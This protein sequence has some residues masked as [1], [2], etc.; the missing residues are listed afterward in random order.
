[1]MGT[2]ESAGYHVDCH[3]TLALLVHMHTLAFKSPAVTQQGHGFPCK[4]HFFSPV[5]HLSPL[6]PLLKRQGLQ[7]VPTHLFYIATSI[8]IFLLCPCYLPSFH[9]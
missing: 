8:Y 6:A 2:G 9:M 5:L 1:M 3:E 4:W 7:E